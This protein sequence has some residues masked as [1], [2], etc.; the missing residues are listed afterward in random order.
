MERTRNILCLALL[1][2]FLGQ[3]VPASAQCGE[4][5]PDCPLAPPQSQQI[6]THDKG[7]ILYSSP[8]SPPSSLAAFNLEPVVFIE[9]VAL[10]ASEAGSD[11][12]AAQLG[13]IQVRLR[14]QDP[15]DVS[16]GVQ[17]LGMALEALGGSAPTSD[18]L[19]GFLLDNNYLYDFGTGVEELALAARSFGYA[20][21]LAFHGWSLAQLQAE[22]AAG[23]PVVVDLGANGPDQ[24]GHFVTVT[25]IAPDG[26]RVAYSDPILGER[27]ATTAEFLA[28]WK[29]QGDSGV[30]VA[31][32]PP[33]PPGPDYE[34]W[35]A[36][37]LA[38]MATLALAPGMLNRRTRPG[39]GG[40]IVDPGDGSTPISTVSLEPPYA[41]PTG[42][43]WVQGDAVYET[44]TST[45]LEYEE[46]P[47]MV[48]KQVQ[49]G[50]EYEKIPYTK[51]IELDEGW[52]VTTYKTETYVAYYKSVPYTAYRYQRYPTPYGWYTRR[53]AY[54]AYR[55]QPVYRTRQVETGKYWHENW[56]THEYTE[57]KTIEVPVYEMQ[58]VQEGVQRVPVERELSEQVLVGYEWRLVEEPAPVAELEPNPFLSYENRYVVSNPLNVREQPD[59]ESQRIHVLNP[60]DRVVKTGRTEDR[61][62]SAWFEIYFD[63][64]DLSKTGWVN[65]S[66]LQKDEE[67]QIEDFVDPRQVKLAELLAEW[68]TLTPE[69]QAAIIAQERS[70]LQ[71][72]WAELVQLVDLPNHQYLAA[73]QDWL[74]AE[75][76]VLLEEPEW[77]QTG[78]I[79]PTVLQ[80]YVLTNEKVEALRAVT[81]AA[82]DGVLELD[83]STWSRIAA[84]LDV[85]QAELK[86]MVFDNAPWDSEVPARVGNF[87]I[88]LH[89]VN[90]NLAVLHQEPAPDSPPVSPLFN[91]M[92]PPNAVEWNGEYKAGV[93]FYGNPCVYYHVKY[94]YKGQ[95]FTGWVPNTA[96]SPVLTEVGDLPPIT[97]AVGPNTFGWNMGWKGWSPYSTG[98]PAQFLNLQLLFKNLG[99]AGDF[100]TSHKNLCGQLAVME[101]LNVSLEEGFRRFNNIHHDILANSS[102]TT[103]PRDLLE[104]T[105]TL[106][107]WKG[108][109]GSGLEQLSAAMRSNRRVILLVG[110]SN[111]VVTA[112][113]SVGHWVHLL[114]F[115]TEE[116]G[117]ELKEYAYIYNPYNNV[118]EKVEKEIFS[119]SWKN[120]G[121]QFIAAGRE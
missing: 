7:G 115:G 21:S 12:G 74:E 25:G 72:M 24:P 104:F 43:K 40:A 4:G 22:L 27:I 67:L 56:V 51:R 76:S 49:I 120:Q 114:R 82:E 96:L 118:R 14:T 78:G 1:A 106:E 29:L 70:E 113:G 32:T 2:L 54:T 5:D 16:C 110:T 98:S 100:P 34:P 103:S 13:R 11:P 77:Y 84:G 50:I 59:P 38:M 111:G 109:S 58:W 68:N 3:S 55:S 19:L 97:N 36:A 47:K 37:A 71:A 15:A 92:V 41:A 101:A 80:E 105:N 90:I 26:S 112:D 17:S 33:A 18:T 121:M 31:T 75:I 45:V 86:L 99:I 107:G 28:L 23:R 48:Q 119:S 95:E 8:V 83:D 108:L 94:S 9:P 10:P 52:W 66:Y 42:M 69:Q 64:H 46:I 85:S 91:Y 73:Y 81:K 44:R 63:E 102:V 88:T 57:Y 89:I 60:G 87:P 65:S 117:G 116:V 93:D 20:G 35:A 53:V 79:P 62:G 39:V 61:N 6:A 30:A